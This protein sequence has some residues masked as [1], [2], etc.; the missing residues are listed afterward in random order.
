MTME[1]YPMLTYI[2]S[3]IDYLIIKKRQKYSNEGNMAI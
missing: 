2:D 3:V 1:V